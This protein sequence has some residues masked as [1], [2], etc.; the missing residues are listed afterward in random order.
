M[1]SERLVGRSDLQGSL[2][3]S[4]GYKSLTGPWGNGGQES[5]TLEAH[6]KR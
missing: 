6:R 1:E 5:C 3:P 2:Q 4:Q